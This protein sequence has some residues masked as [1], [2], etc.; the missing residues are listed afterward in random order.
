[1]FSRVVARTVAFDSPEL[2]ARD[3]VGKLSESPSPGSAAR[4]EEWLRGRGR[5]S[6]PR[7]FRFVNIGSPYT[8]F[9]RLLFVTA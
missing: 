2:L 3:S 6:S 4:S 5:G 9:R 7:D 1:M 8:P